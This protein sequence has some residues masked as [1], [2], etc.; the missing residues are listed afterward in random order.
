MK[1]LNGGGKL[2]LKKR[3][4]TSGKYEWKVQSIDGSYLGSIF[5]NH[6]F[7][8]LKFTNDIINYILL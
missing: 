3:D 5:R 1:E 2:L 8:L 6:N 4:L 7:Q